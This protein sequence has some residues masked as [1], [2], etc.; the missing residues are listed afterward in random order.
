MM[1]SWYYEIY[2]LNLICIIVFLNCPTQPPM[3]SQHC[4]LFSGK[5]KVFMKIGKIFILMSPS[6][7]RNPENQNGNSRCC[8]ANKREEKIN[9]EHFWKNSTVSH[10]LLQLIIS[11][12]KEKKERNYD[13]RRKIKF[14]N[15]W[16]KFYFQPS[17][18]TII[19]S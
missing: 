17:I 3:F 1:K 4:T 10:Q 16:K 5:I 11:N 15:F 14:E 18:V 8:E 9:F 12:S 2:S 19:Y 6:I 13:V 7:D